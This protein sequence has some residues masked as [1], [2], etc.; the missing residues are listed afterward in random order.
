[1]YLVHIPDLSSVM[2][3]YVSADTV[4]LSQR[5]ESGASEAAVARVCGY[6]HRKVPF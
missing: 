5:T 6:A 4:N 1:M 2:L 3:L